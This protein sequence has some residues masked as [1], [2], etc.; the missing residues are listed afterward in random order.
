M[1]INI[2]NSFHKKKQNVM[3]I[4]VKNSSLSFFVKKITFLLQDLKIIPNDE[5]LFNLLKYI[6]EKDFPQKS[7]EDLEIKRI[8]ARSGGAKKWN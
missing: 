1:T 5:V 6:I 7:K 8:K 2:N 4:L 3:F